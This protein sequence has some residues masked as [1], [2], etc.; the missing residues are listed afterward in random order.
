MDE[1]LER[2]AREMLAHVFCCDPEELS[3]DEVRAARAV[4]AFQ[5]A[6]ATNYT[7]AMGEAAE[8]YHKSFKFAHPLPAQWRWH[9]L[10]DTMLAASRRHHE[11]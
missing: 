7:S 3:K 5:A 11:P 4:L 10:W 6:N 1:V 2:R 9:E 8:R